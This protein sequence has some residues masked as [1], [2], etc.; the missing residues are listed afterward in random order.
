MQKEQ[1]RI[2]WIDQVKGWGILMVAYG[3]N[4]PLFEEYIYTFHMP[5][6]FLVSGIFHSKKTTIT[7]LKKRAKQLLIP[8]FLWAFMLYVF[9]LII[10]RFYG[11]PIKLTFSPVD[12]FLGIFYAKVI[13]PIWTGEYLCGFYL[14]C[15]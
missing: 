9:W 2:H 1:N 11:D 14:V 8:Y 15:S 13:E 5:L 3:H 12:N 10:G 6:F 7:V 4:F